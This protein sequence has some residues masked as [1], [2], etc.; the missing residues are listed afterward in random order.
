MST[1]TKDFYRTLGVS[2]KASQDEIKKAYR[3]LAKKYHPDA[4]RNDK[5]AP[6]RFK[7]VGEA[8]GVLSD[9]EKR[10]QYDQMR[11]LSSFGFGRTRQPSRGAGQPN[12]GGGQARSEARSKTGSPQASRSGPSSP[13]HRW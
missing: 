12:R 11:R 13:D 10:K 4:N 8:Y 9:P 6:G 2:E 5:K 3:T 1:A 7:G